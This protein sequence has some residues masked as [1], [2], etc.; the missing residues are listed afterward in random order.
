MI[1]G[2]PC[3]KC[4]LHM[5]LAFVKQGR[6]GFDVRTYECVKCGNVETLTV[7]TKTGKWRAS[8]LRPV[9]TENLNPDV[10]CTENPIRVHPLTE[11]PRLGG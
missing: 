11:S 7:E 8:D 5:L 2:R 3:T 10:V 4:Q 9:C 1:G 6:I